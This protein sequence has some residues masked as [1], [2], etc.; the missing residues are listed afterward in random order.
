MKATENW[1]DT[2]TS[3][4]DDA[5]EKV[6]AL[7]APDALFWGTVSEQVR[8]TPQHVREYFVSFP[9]LQCSLQILA[10][11]VGVSPVAATERWR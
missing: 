4:A 10:L 1:R 7:Y 3:G 8:T 6:A 9:H 5:P 2:L 11:S